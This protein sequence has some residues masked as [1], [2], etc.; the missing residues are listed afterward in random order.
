MLFFHFKVVLA[1]TLILMTS[2]I[3]VANQDFGQASAQW[4][5]SKLEGLEENRRVWIEEILETNRDPNFTNED[6]DTPL[7]IAVKYALDGD[8]NSDDWFEVVMA[9][10][11]AGADPTLPSFQRGFWSNT[12]TTPLAE[13]MNRGNHEITIALIEARE[14]LAGGL[15]FVDGNDE[16]AHYYNNVNYYYKPSESD[17]PSMRWLGPYLLSN[18]YSEK[19]LFYYGW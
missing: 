6:G 10:L 4:V 8:H 11:E 13:A 1:F 19:S 15:P 7:M 9:L 17:L 12:T 14:R 16:S 18:K 5:Q 3:S 2:T